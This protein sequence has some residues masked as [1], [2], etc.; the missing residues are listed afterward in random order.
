M[1]VVVVMHIQLLQQS[2]ARGVLAAIL[3]IATMPVMP[4][5]TIVSRPR[6]QGV[7]LQP[8]VVMLVMMAL[9]R[10]GVQAVV[11]AA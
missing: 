1:T 4:V 10:L 7:V 2:K 6:V 9:L 8:V 5:K 11:T 3:L